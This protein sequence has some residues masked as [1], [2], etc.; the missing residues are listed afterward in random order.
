MSDRCALINVSYRVCERVYC[1]SRYLSNVTVAVVCYDGLSGSG[2][3]LWLVLS[4]E[5][6]FLKCR[7]LRQVVMRYLSDKVGFVDVVSV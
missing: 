7:D 6:R 2:F 5:R 1:R 4:V 3:L